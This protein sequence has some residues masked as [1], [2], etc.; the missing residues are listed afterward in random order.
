MITKRVHY[1]IGKFY[2][3]SE[4]QIKERMER[5]LPTDDVPSGLLRI[6]FVL[7]DRTLKKIF[8]SKRALANIL[9]KK[10]I[11]EVLREYKRIFCEELVDEMI[12]PYLSACDMKL[13]E[14]LTETENPIMTIARDKELIPD[15]VVLQR[16]LGKYQKLRGKSDNSARDIKR[17]ADK[18]NLPSDVIMTIKDFKQACG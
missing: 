5:N 1:W 7:I 10:N 2:D 9:T 3:K 14:S 13:R 15:K 11:I 4:Q 17:Y 16:A 12:K 6:E 18:Y 8:G